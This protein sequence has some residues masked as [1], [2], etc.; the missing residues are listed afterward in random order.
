MTLPQTDPAACRLERDTALYFLDGDI[1]L[2]TGTTAFRVHEV[3]LSRHSAVCAT[4]LQRFHVEYAAKPPHER[5]TLD[6]CPVL[7]VPDTAYDLKQLVLGMYDGGVEGV[8]S[9]FQYESEN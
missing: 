5:E 1:V 9:L 3:V 4:A 6:D 8:P 7:R 2:A